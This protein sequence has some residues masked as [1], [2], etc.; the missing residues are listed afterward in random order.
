MLIWVVQVIDVPIRHIQPSTTHTKIWIMI[1]TSPQPHAPYFVQYIILQQTHHVIS[2]KHMTHDITTI[3]TP[4]SSGPIPFMMMDM[5]QHIFMNDMF[6]AL[7]T[8]PK[9]K[10]PHHEWISIFITCI[11]S[12]STPSLSTGCQR[13]VPHV[14]HHPPNVMIMDMTQVY[15]SAWVSGSS[16]IHKDPDYDIDKHPFIHLTC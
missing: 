11:P 7:C 2:P 13:F 8:C 15:I 10:D 6:I 5:T 14:S 9:H 4:I 3:T 16:H 12:S 1:F